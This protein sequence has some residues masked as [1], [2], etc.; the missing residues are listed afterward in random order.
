[1]KKEKLRITLKTGTIS[2][3]YIVLGSYIDNVITYK[4]NNKL[5]S[6]M[7]IDLNK[8]ILIKENIDYK[9][10]INLD[11][12]KHTNTKITLLK[13]GKVLNLKTETKKCEIKDKNIDIIYSIIDTNEEVELKIV[14]GG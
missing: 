9:I 5:S 10:E 3:E 11:L 7:I 12:D 8:K 1:M 4:E 14:I 2:E 6:N 13:E